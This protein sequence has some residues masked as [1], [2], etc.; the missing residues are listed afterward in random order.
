LSDSQ[1]GVGANAAQGLKIDFAAFQRA[2]FVRQLMS[3]LR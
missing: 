1:K 2:P 3:A